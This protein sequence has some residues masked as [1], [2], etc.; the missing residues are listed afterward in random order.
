MLKLKFYQIEN[1]VL[2]R[3]LEQPERMFEYR[4]SDNFLLASR[5]YPQMNSNE[6]F[7]RG[8]D[9]AYDNNL[10]SITFLTTEKAKDFI[11]TAK[12]AVREYNEKDF[13]EENIKES[14]DITEYI[15]E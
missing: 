7:V 5:A 1:V 13:P 9:K 3:I 4:S 12:K 10:S 11:A 15:A 14:F 6:I 2:M 8:T